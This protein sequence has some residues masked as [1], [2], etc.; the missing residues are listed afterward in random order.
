[1]TEDK[2][3]LLDASS[4]RGAS[5]FARTIGEGVRRV[6]TAIASFGQKALKGIQSGINKALSYFR[7]PEYDPIVR[8]PEKTP[9]GLPP[10]GTYTIPF[11]EA[12]HPVAGT[13][14][15]FY[16]DLHRSTYEFNGVVFD[17]AFATAVYKDQSGASDFAREDRLES[18]MT[19]EISRNFVISVAH[20]D[21]PKAATSPMMNALG[22][23]YFER[24]TKTKYTAST[25]GDFAYVI[26]DHSFEFSLFSQLE[27]G[28]LGD[29]VEVPPG[30][31]HI[32]FSVQ[33][34]SNTGGSF[35]D[36][37]DPITL[38]TTDNNRY[39]AFKLSLQR[40]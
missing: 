26:V 25:L 3:P 16:N 5:A 30:R 15:Q 37:L 14:K 22:G 4:P 8:L 17:Q 32:R 40:T 34:P 35:L 13:P 7:G 28:G 6:A 2:T 39:G 24:N 20:Q 19:N 23:A 29:P 21:L 18:V 9:D 33:T 38:G 10:E 31:A 27:E 36:V 12:S 11:T 1:M